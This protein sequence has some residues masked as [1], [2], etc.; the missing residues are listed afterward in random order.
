M[1][2]RWVPASLAIKF[3]HLATDDVPRVV[4]GL[5]DLG[6]RVNAAQD[7]VFNIFWP[8]FVSSELSH[9]V[10]YGVVQGFQDDVGNGQQL[11]VAD[12]RSD[13]LDHLRGTELLCRLHSQLTLVVLKSFE[14][15]SVGDHA[16]ARQVY[17]REIIRHDVKLRSLGLS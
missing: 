10:L 4:L 1:L 6:E 14:E 15:G 13:R 16:H 9:T 5:F 8:R 17:V 7:E 3:V 2:R 12:H 11:G